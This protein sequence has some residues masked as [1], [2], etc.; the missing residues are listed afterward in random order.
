M[1]STLFWTAFGLLIACVAGFGLAA[2]LT[3]FEIVDAVNSKLPPLERFEEYWWGFDKMERLRWE[4]R[5][6]FPSGRLLRRYDL[7]LLAGLSGLLSV[8]FLLFFGS[9]L[10]GRFAS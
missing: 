1:A 5:R 9:A 8:A 3:S 4:Y 10:L 6:L 7:C 2:T